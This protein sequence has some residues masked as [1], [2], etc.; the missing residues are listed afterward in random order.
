MAPK[1]RF[2]KYIRSVYIP[3]KAFT[4]INLKKEEYIYQKT[5]LIQRQYAT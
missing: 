2:L 5:W 3:Q 1:T 4:T